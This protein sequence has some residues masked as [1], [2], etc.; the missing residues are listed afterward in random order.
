MN[1]V[2]A[3]EIASCPDL[4]QNHGEEAGAMV[5]I[6]TLAEFSEP[7]AAAAEA[8]TPF[9]NSDKVKP[10]HELQKEQAHHRSILINLAQ[11]YTPTE[12][13]ESTG[14]S[15]A[16]INNLRAQ[17]WAQKFLAEQ[18]EKHGA[19]LIRNQLMGG[20]ADAAKILLDSV[21]ESNPLGLKPKDRSDAA[22]KLIERLYPQA[23]TVL[24]KN[25]DAEELTDA[26]LQQI[27]RGNM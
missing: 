4:G 14:W 20:A 3:I 13:A 1:A 21:A 12:V 11:G 27:A 24:H 25:V 19:K 22:H 2:E 7:G 8:F 26:E 23:Q 17:P 10:V 16:M 18:L 5:D 15:A 9:F 6:S